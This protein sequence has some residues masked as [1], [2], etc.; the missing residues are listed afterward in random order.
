MGLISKETEPKHFLLI[1]LNSGQE[2]GS[3]KKLISFSNKKLQKLGKRATKKVQCSIP[4]FLLCPA[5]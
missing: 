3:R 4:R 5:S 1:L 2:K